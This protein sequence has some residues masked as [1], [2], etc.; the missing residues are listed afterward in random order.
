[1]IDRDEGPERTFL[2]DLQFDFEASED[3]MLGTV[4]LT[5]AM[6]APGSDRPLLSVL[7]T[8]ADVF[9]GMPVTIHRPGGLRPAEALRCLRAVIPVLIGSMLPISPTNCLV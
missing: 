4:T 9:T 2:H 1:M 3:G 8:V 5:P 6:L 7:A